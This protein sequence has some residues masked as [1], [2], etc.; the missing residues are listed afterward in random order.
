[1][2]SGS[3][4]QSP[5][6][7]GPG[8]PGYGPGNQGSDREDEEQKGP[9]SPTPG[10]APG[11]QPPPPPGPQSPAGPPSVPGPSEG[12]PPPPPPGASSP[13]PAFAPPAGAQPPPAVS[14]P[15]SGPQAPGYGG[16]VPP[17]GWQQPL[18]TPAFQAAPDEL[19]SWGSRVGAYLIDALI[20][21][22]VLAVGIL[23][24]VGIAAANKTAGIVL[25]IIIGIALVVV[26][27]AYAPYLLAREGARNG[28]T[29]GKQ[30]V[31]IRVMRDNG[32]P[33]DLGQGF[34]REFVVKGLLFGTVGSFFLY[35]PTLLDLLWPLWDDQDRALH[36]MVVTTH[37][38]KA[39]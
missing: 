38:V 19:A 21:L 6:P 28:Q 35:I 3:G 12:G 17:G 39:E 36:D 14:P 33:M 27:L 18:S 8:S 30:A 24:I 5:G 23:V 1:M 20:L 34:L 2:E 37:V 7:F 15:G 10:E 26:L 4:P 16:P 9:Q 11:S 13:P 29:Y 32:Q 31:N 25:G 22:A